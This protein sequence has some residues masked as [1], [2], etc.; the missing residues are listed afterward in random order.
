MP[1]TLY[2]LNIEAMINN[3]TGNKTSYVANRSMIKDQL[4][5]RYKKLL[6]KNKTFKY[7]IYK[8]K[9]KYLFH[10]RIPSETFENSKF[11]YDVVLEFYPKD[12]ESEVSKSIKSYYINM[13]SNSPSFLFTYAYVIYQNNMSIKILNSKISKEARTTRPRIKNPVESYGFEKSCYYACLF[14][15]ENNLLEKIYLDSHKS[16]FNKAKFLKGIKSCDEKLDEYNKY[17]KEESEKKKKEK[18]KANKNKA[19]TIK[20]SKKVIMKANMK[21]DMSIKKK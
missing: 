11:Y 6:Q 20:K 13:Y 3:P 14:I 2:P 8:G 7:E 4:Y 5:I 12:V 21:H 16:H 19:V 1:E 15:K 9:S 10:F 17:K 18:K